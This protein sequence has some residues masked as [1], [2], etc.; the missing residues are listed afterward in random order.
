MFLLWLH[1]DFVWHPSAPDLRL[2]NT[3]RRCP[4]IWLSN[5]PSGILAF[6]NFFSKERLTFVDCWYCCPF[7]LQSFFSPLLIQSY[8]STFSPSILEY[9]MEWNIVMDAQTEKNF[10]T[11]TLLSYVV[12]YLPKYCKSIVIVQKIDFEILCFY[13]RLGPKK[14]FLQKGICDCV[15]KL[16]SSPNGLPKPIFWIYLDNS[17]Q[18]A[19][20]HDFLNCILSCRNRARV[21][22]P[23]PYLTACAEFSW[24][25]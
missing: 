16:R 15:S 21:T 14:R 6:R 22:S 1:L 12:Y 5:G 25:F 7:N 13:D 20:E 4:P 9:L 23:R 10:F 19:Q 3:K 17:S 18:C 11:L 8:T 24:S 2:F